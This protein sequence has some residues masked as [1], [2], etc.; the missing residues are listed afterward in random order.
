[1]KNTFQYTKFI[2]LVHFLPSLLSFSKVVKF[3]GLAKKKIV[4]WRELLKISLNCFN[5]EE[6]EFK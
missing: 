5:W 6:K 2:L 1:M 3:C 4:F